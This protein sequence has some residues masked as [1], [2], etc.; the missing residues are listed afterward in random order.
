MDMGDV[1]QAL[2]AGTIDA[3]ENPVVS[4][5]NRSFQ[6]VAKYVVRDGHILATSMWICGESFYNTLT[7]EQKQILS[8]CAD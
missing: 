5:A 7:D 6:E 4:L 3:V 1:Y 8:E 2:Q